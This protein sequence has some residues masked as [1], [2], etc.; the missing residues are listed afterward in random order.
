[1]LLGQKHRRPVGV[2]AVALVLTG[3][4]LAAGPVRAA[5]PP[6]ILEA[7]SAQVSSASARVLAR[8]TPN[9]ALTSYHVDY[10]TAAAYEANLAASKSGF[11]GALRSPLSTEVSLGSG[12]APITT[13]QQLFSLSPGTVYRYRFVVKNSQGTVETNPPLTFVTQPPATGA[14]LADS[15][16]WEQVSP[17]DKNGG[18]V[19]SP[20]AAV[21]GAFQSAA[22]G[23]S[24]AYA[25]TATFAA[26]PQGAP[27]LSQYLAVRGSA[28]WPTV[29]LT[30][31]LFA[32]TFDFTSAEDPYRLFSPDLAR[33]LLLNGEHCR[34]GASGC[35]VDN[36]PLAGTDAP[37]GYQNYYL[38]EGSSYTAL[39]G[40]ANAGFL[41]LAPKDFDLDF[42]GAS[43]D[44]R[45]SVLSTCAALTANATEAPLGEGC[46]PAQQNLYLHS[47]GAG[48][49]LLNLLPAQST[50]TPGASLASQSGAVSVD[51]SRVYF[52]QG[53]DLYLREGSQTKLVAAGGGFQM[54]TPSGAVAFYV[55]AGHL[56]RYE[57]AGAGSSADLTPSGGVAGVLGASE[58]GSV[59]YYQDGTGLQRWSS[60]T[61]T[62][63]ASGANA[64]ASS[65]YPPAIGTA[66]VSADGGKLVF[67]SVARL[68]N[69]DNTDLD[70]GL[71]DSQLFLYDAAGAGSL[72]CVSCNPTLQRPIGSSSIP[73]ALPN[74][75][76]QAY[77]PRVLSANGRRV[78][79]DSADALAI[80][81]T[82]DATDAYE[83]EAQGEGNCTRAGGCV[84]LISGG[85]GAGGRF[86]DA[87]ADGAD[88]FFVTD[89]S[90]VAADP[91]AADLYDARA[92]GGFPTAPAPIPCTGDACQ[93]LPPEPVDQTLTTLL[94]GPGNPPVRYPG[95]RCK[96]GQVQRNGKCVKKKGKAKK[97]KASKSTRSRS[98]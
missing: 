74:G 35:G 49:T 61:T 57:A 83:W 5:S 18:Q 44:L 80:T 8:I 58:G 43:P 22:N 73:G 55:A 91:G 59:V 84:S 93:P 14:V 27:P 10:I 96:K 29:N 16:G 86:L 94:S 32:G 76:T 67:L 41:T 7:W 12:N 89:E 66:R 11:T 71:P 60:G 31:P 17:I 46:D 30:A 9:G 85:R 97:K 26:N 82:N 47:P 87:S 38:R 15:R 52:S 13:N 48:L 70:T 64:A 92:G 39:L 78:F 37:A 63:V 68:T 79:F 20:S 54:A 1:M 50:G 6:T 36:P 42:A 69:Y 4:A 75:S 62:S 95:N 72:T 56:Y 34:G 45:Y 77:K 51:G 88:A 24:V 90:L 65:D 19:V 33:S 81:D 23:Q 28:D 25:S 21:G 40:S 53:G 3:L 2:V 98:R